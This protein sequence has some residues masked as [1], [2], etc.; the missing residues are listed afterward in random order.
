MKIEET[1]G[2]WTP[3]TA[4]E[5]CSSLRVHKSKLCWG[6]DACEADATSLPIGKHDTIQYFTALVEFACSVYSAE[7]YCVC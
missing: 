4:A 5:L 3:T 7:I 2:E 6:F 1:C